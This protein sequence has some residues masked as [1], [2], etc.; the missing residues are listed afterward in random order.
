MFGQ[1]ICVGGCCGK[2]FFADDVF[3]GSYSR[4]DREADD[5]NAQLTDPLGR[6]GWFQNPGITGTAWLRHD[7]SRR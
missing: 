4:G 2:W 1:F 3:A 5:A 6:L 7:V